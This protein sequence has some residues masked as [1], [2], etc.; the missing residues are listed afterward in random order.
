MDEVEVM[1]RDMLGIYDPDDELWQ[2]VEGFAK[3]AYSRGWR[4]MHGWQASDERT[5]E[6]DSDECPACLRIMQEY[7][8]GAHAAQRIISHLQKM[9]TDDQVPAHIRA[10]CDRMLVE[11]FGIDITGDQKAS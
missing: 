7:R 6:H 8:A 3:V 2:S 9:A 4:R 1:A 11:E 5:W 10:D